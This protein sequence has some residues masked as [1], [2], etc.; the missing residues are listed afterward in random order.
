MAR[1]FLRRSVLV[2]AA[3]LL[4]A[5]GAEAKP[6]SRKLDRVLNEVLASNAGG[7]QREGRPARNDEPT[8]GC[9]S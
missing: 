8:S 6:G 1:N 7:K 4:C 2:V 3:V 9:F 5:S